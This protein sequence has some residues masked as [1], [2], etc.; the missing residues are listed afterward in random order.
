MSTALDVARSGYS[1]LV[2][3]EQAGHTRSGVTNAP[4]P[5][6]NGWS[7]TP[8]AAGRNRRNHQTDRG[9]HA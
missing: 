9:W 6:F 5:S 1:R 2:S 4:S 7:Q 3:M 8:V